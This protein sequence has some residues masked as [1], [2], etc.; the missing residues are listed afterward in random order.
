MNL[1]I[2][3]ISIQTFIDPCYDGFSFQK[4]LLLLGL[5]LLFNQT[6]AL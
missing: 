5:G 4:H 3:S 6:K 1:E 2:L